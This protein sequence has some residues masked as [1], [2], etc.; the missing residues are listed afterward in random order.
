MRNINMGSEKKEI[1][2]LWDTFSYDSSIIPQLNTD[3]CNILLLF[4]GSL[5][6]WSKTRGVKGFKIEVCQFLSNYIEKMLK[7]KSPNNDIPLQKEQS[8]LA[9]VQK[10]RNIEFIQLCKALFEYVNEHGNVV[11][12]LIHACIAS[13]RTLC[14]IKVF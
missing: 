13:P 5:Q 11:G 6:I 10:N 14:S 12:G 2:T 8:L 4:H 1:D 3:L 9:R 7:N